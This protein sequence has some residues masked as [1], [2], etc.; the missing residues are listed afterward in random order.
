M[1]TK[2]GR[3]YE[4]DMAWCH[5]VMEILGIPSFPELIR[6]WRNQCILKRQQAFYA[7]ITDKEKNQPL[8]GKCIQK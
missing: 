5:H 2:T 7:K 1:N 4:K 8:K 3:V 6:E